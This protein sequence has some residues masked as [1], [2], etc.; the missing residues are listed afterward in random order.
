MNPVEARN[1]ESFLSPMLRLNPEERVTARQSLEH[2][3]LRGLP[4][5]AVTEQAARASLKVQRLQPPT[6]PNI[7]GRRDALESG[8]AQESEPQATAQQESSPKR[9]QNHDPNVWMEY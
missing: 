9:L 6:D 5:P 4:C 2:P 3:W 7:A 1:L 8:E